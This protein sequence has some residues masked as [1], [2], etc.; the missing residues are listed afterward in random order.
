MSRQEQVVPA[1]MGDFPRI[2][3]FIEQACARAGF[4]RAACLR[5]TLA[6]EELFT[7]TVVH[8]HGGDSDHPV[9]IAVD[10]EPGRIAITYEDTAP[11]HDPFATLRSPAARDCVEDRAVG[12]LG[13]L[14][15]GSVVEH[16]AYACVDGRNR[17][18]LVVSAGR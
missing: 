3:S 8:G 4:P 12:G 2:A 16:H 1:R 18:S 13:V 11:P 10:V 7:N 14:L 15:I 6:L 5:L 17:I 9:A